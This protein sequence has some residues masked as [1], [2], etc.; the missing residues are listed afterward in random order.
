MKNSF[1]F[2]ETVMTRPEG[3]TVPLPEVRAAGV[4]ELVSKAESCLGNVALDLY[5]GDDPAYLGKTR[6]EAALLSLARASTTD[7]EARREFIDRIMGKPKQRVD[8]TNVSL[9]LSG[10]LEQ[11][12]EG[13]VIEVSRADDE[14]FFK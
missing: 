13:E 11:I 7:P 12:A 5:D 2:Q 4:Q 8:S 10:F 6:L 9:T 1:K 3:S 14:E